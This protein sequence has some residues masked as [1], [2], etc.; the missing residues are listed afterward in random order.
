MI[1]LKNISK[2]YKTAIK[3]SE[4]LKNI[5]IS[6]EDGDIYGIIG[7]SGAGKSTLI[8]CINYLSPPT[9][10]SV[11]IDGVDLGTLSKSELLKVRRSIA[12]VFQNFNLF[13]QRTVLSNVCFPM[14]ISGVSKKEAK[15][16]AMHLLSLVGIEASARKSTSQLSGGQKQRVAIARALA[17]DPKV[18]LCDEPTSALDPVTSRSLIELLKDINKKIGVT[19]IVITHQMEVVE[20][21]CNNVAVLSKGRI[22]EQGAVKD[23]LFNPTSAETK[24]LLS[25]KI[26]T[27]ENVSD[28]KRLKVCLSGNSAYEPIV[29]NL[30][31]EFGAVS[32]ISANVQEKDGLTYGEMILQFPN[33]SAAFENA[34]SYLAE[35]NIRFEEVDAL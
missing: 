9:S 24:N 23:V 32:I 3:T 20:Q 15:E 31:V 18:L 12:M 4:A 6:I 19:I 1:E 22:V 34:K 28:G 30:T 14:E 29:S 10:G 33:N 5:S 26:K 11:A 13:S 21:L 2:T 16:K 7:A 35:R 25:L 8:R 27:C 17:C